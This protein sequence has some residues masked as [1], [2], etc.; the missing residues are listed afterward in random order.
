[1][2]ILTFISNISAAVAWPMAVVIIA[3]ILKDPLVELLCNVKKLKFKDVELDFEKESTV[4][5]QIESSVSSQITVEENQ[6]KLAELSPR[7]AILEAWLELEDTLANAAEKEGMQRTRPGG[8]SGK[9]VPIDSLAFVQRLSA[10]GKLSQTS[11]ERFLK[12]RKIRNKAVHVTDNVISQEDA[13]VFIRLVAEIKF[14][15]KGI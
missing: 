11:N 5:K 1:M 4:L 12:L 14:D 8:V 7:G 9:P 2:D 15:I 3:F 13:E 10:S 6:L